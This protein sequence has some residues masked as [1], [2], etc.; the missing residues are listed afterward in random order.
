[1]FL[2]LIRFCLLI[3]VFFGLFQLVSNKTTIKKA[4]I[5]FVVMMGIGMTMFIA[6]LVNLMQEIS[7]VI[8]FYSVYQVIHTFIINK[9]YEILKST[10]IYFFIVVS[11]IFVLLFQNHYFVQYDDFSHWGLVARE[12]IYSNRFP[13]F[14]DEIVTFQ[15]YPTG[16]AGFIYFV[17]KILG[18]S[19][20]NMFFAQSLIYLSCIIPLF[21]FIKNKNFLSYI[22]IILYF[23]YLIFGNYGMRTI[24]VDTILSCVSIAITA[25][26]FLSYKNGEVSEAFIPLI[27]GN[28]FL[29]TVKNSG[30]LFVVVTLII[31]MVFLTEEKSKW[32]IFHLLCMVFTPF[33][34]DLL[35]NKHIEMV[36]SE[37]AL[38]KHSM[39][40]DNYQSILGSKT[41]SDIVSI[42]ESL[43]KR[44]FNLKFVDVQL[45]LLM[46]LFLTIFFMFNY[47]SNKKEGDRLIDYTSFR[48]LI[49]ISGLYIT[50]QIG[51]WF[52]YIF[53]MPIK[54]SLNLAGYARYNVTIVAYLLGIFVINYL[55][56]NDQKSTLSLSRIILITATFFTLSFS[57]FQQKEAISQFISNEVYNESSRSLL[58]KIISSND[59]TNEDSILIYVSNMTEKESNDSLY[60]QF[61]YEL[62][63]KNIKVIDSQNIDSILNNKNEF[64]L[65]TLKEDPLILEYLNENNLTNQGKII[66]MNSG[67]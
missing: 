50:Y 45:I 20:G 44:I 39:S 51:L 2:L 19:E 63:N 26:I 49:G 21:A 40:L 24:Y 58:A 48:L 56:E 42:S 36:F 28:S 67:E 43:F 4:Y 64:L 34:T 32:N 12:I 41:S 52:M 27:L 65:I 62:R 14:T 31:Y 54:E 46:V 9:N 15:S 17:V 8:L 1:M 23:L 35:W 33:A 53:S 16:S 5:P 37:A 61:K 60:F 29:V 47:Y 10:E 7:I 57:V 6:G 3:L 11:L 30:L 13:N 38:S 55:S 66:R 59:L 22:S 25:I 18:F